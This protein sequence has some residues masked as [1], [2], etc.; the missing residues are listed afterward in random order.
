M[1]NLIAL[2]DK[3][4][5][6]V[7]DGMVVGLGSG[8]ASSAFIEALGRRVAQ[9]LHV[10]G[11]ATSQASEDLAKR[12]NIPLVTLDD[13][14]WI[15]L[16]CDGA[17][18]VDPQGDCIKGYGGALVREKVVAA[19]SKQ[20]AILIGEEKLV[21]QLGSRGKLPVEVVPFAASFCQRELAALGLTPQFREQDRKPF[22]TDN[23]NLILDCGTGPIADPLQ[24]EQAIRAIP[25][26]VG[27]G[28]FL[29]MVATVLVERNG[30]VEVRRFPR[31]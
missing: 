23:G 4:L 15:D 28:L 31:G 2:A 13:V 21:P 26:I 9:G 14:D 5:E 29:D 24:L 6:L 10:L 1:P 25:G 27:T 17:D 11:I 8:K 16:T 7:R 18:E 22:R 20:L 30:S 19:A 3:A 12:L